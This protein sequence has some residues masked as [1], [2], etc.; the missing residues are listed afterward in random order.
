MAATREEEIIRF[1][2]SC[3]LC[4]SAVKLNIEW[5]TALFVVKTNINITDE[6][7]TLMALYWVENFQLC[8]KHLWLFTKHI[9]FMTKKIW[10]DEFLS[11][12]NRIWRNRNS[13]N[14]KQLIIEKM[15]W[16]VDQV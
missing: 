11:Q 5:Q 13:E 7:T 10:L 16:F 2:F 6:V 4:T 12:M 8:N 3:C 15:E 9:D 1:L 14:Y